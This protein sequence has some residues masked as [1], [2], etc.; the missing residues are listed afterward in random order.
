MSISVTGMNMP[1]CCAECELL[2]DYMRC[3]VTGTRADFE[4]MNS[5]RLPNCPLKEI[6]DNTETVEKSELWE[7]G[8]ADGLVVGVKWVERPKGK[9]INTMEFDE[10]Y[11]QVYKC[12]HCGG[13]V[14]GCGARNFCPKC[15]AQML[16]GD[17]N[18]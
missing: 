6:I 2:Y 12:S 3:S 9:W 5:E 17:N 8:F 1:K 15:G 16:E 18:E 14:L 13:E 11:G 10:Y 4:K 7:E